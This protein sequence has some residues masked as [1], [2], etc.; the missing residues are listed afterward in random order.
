MIIIALK[1]IKFDFESFRIFI[2]RWACKKIKRNFW[3]KKS[4]KTFP[5]HRNWQVW[6][7]LQTVSNFRNS[8]KSQIIGLSIELDFVL[9]QILKEVIYIVMKFR[10]FFLWDFPIIS[11][12][13]KLFLLFDNLVHSLFLELFQ[14]SIGNSWKFI[15]S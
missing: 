12:Q 3:K 11:L 2:D 14:P 15:V 5:H 4:P 7:G 8:S 6:R 10:Q 1:L 9:L 13:K